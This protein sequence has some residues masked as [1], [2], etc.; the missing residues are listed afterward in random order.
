MALRF[1]WT[2]AILPVMKKISGTFGKFFREKG[3]LEE[4]KVI[5]FDLSQVEILR[6]DALRLASLSVKQLEFKTLNEVRKDLHSLPPLDGGDVTPGKKDELTEEPENRP[7]NPEPSREVDRDADPELSVGQV[8]IKSIMTKYGDWF[9]DNQKSINSQVA[10]SEDEFLSPVLNTLLEMAERAVKQF[11]NVFKDKAHTITRK[12]SAEGSRS[13]LKEAL[14][15]DLEK[16]EEDYTSDFVSILM[17][18][19][20]L[21]YNINLDSLDSLEDKPKIMEIRDRNE[22][23]RQRSLKARGIDSFGFISKTSIEQ[24]IDVIDAGTAKGKTVNRIAKDIVQDFSEIG[25]RASLIANV[26]AF[27]AI[28][29]GKNAVLQDASKVVKNLMKVWVTLQDSK[30]RDSHAGIHGQIKR[31][32][33]RFSNSLRYPRDPSGMPTEVIRCRCDLIMI[34]KENLDQINI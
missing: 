4:G 27:T 9:S 14:E 30:V 13:K 34:P 2:S 23:G 31:S 24:I 6:E 28:S 8:T 7:S 22:S 5:R 1:M 19:V 11:R 16:L 29:I 10:K 25:T 20:T 33:E 26:E 15:K 3:L 17:A 12:K 18:G 21:G 32:D